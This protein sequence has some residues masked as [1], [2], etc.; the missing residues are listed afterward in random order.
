LTATGKSLIYTVKAVEFAQ[1][2]PM[3]NK[4]DA[5]DQRMARIRTGWNGEGPEPGSQAFGDRARERRDKLRKEALEEKP[6]SVEG[7]IKQQKF[8][9]ESHEDILKKAGE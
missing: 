7:R 2:V 9:T 4:L 1:E 3:A 5:L 6:V 8:R